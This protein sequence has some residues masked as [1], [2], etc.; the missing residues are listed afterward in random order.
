MNRT[1]A[2]AIACAVVCCLSN[3]AVASVMTYGFSNISNNSGVAA[4]VATQFNVDVW[5]V[6]G[7]NSAAFTNFYSALGYTA[8]SPVNIA[9]AS[10]LFIYR[11]SVGIASSISEIYLDDGT[12][13]AQH[14]IFNTM[15]AVSGGLTNFTAG[16]NPGNLPGGNTLN[17]PFVATASFSADAQGNP[18]NGINTAVDLAGLSYTLQGTQDYN[19][20]LAALADGSLRIGL[21]VRG[22]GPNGQ[23]DAFVNTVNN[24]VPEPGTLLIW[25]MGMAAFASACPR[26]RK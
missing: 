11:N 8:V 12:I 21:H 19:D 10:V 13:L 26:R 20:T 6:P 2:L 1:F 5:D 14:Q 7:A 16:A 15:N 17:P 24:V 25:G 23:S 3:G 4:A 9:P 18:S 22:I